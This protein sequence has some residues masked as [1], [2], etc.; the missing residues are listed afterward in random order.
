MCVLRKTLAV[1]LFLLLVGVS[2]AALWLP[3]AKVLLSFHS[4]WSGFPDWLFTFLWM[5]VT[6]TLSTALVAGV[7]LVIGL[8]LH[9]F[10][11]ATR[12]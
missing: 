8:L 10:W 4:S 7:F 1:V 3:V 6:L 9:R 2:F 12:N 11:P 5:G